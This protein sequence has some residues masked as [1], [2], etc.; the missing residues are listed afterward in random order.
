MMPRT[1]I[2]PERRRSDATR[3]TE[4]ILA[5]AISQLR[6]RPDA[7]I[8]SIAREAGLGRVTVYGHF[9]SR[10]AL[11]DAAVGRV[12]A[13]NQKCLDDVAGNPDPVRALES[14]LGISWQLMDQSRSIVMAASDELTP[15]R[16]REL[17]AAFEARI[18]ALIERGQAVGI[19]LSD[20]P[21]WW[22]VTAIH[23]IFHGAANEMAGNRL[24]E[25]K[26]L[27]LL[28]G[29]VLALLRDPAAS[30]KENTS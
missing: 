19:F 6:T 8:T 28:I 7:T 25:G 11:V 20:L 26:V 24:D 4:R 3:N 1:T 10:T 15:A 12:I 22:L 30:P 17:H 29:T 23:R 18:C 16:L 2:T 5:A 9:P 13:D 14:V 27:P 21:A